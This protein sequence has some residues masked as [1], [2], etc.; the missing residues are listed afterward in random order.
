MMRG[1]DI[2]WRPFAGCS[3]SSAGS[4]AVKSRGLPCLLSEHLTN[5]FR[6][7]NTLTLR[8]QTDLRE[9]RW[10]HSGRSHCQP[11]WAIVADSGRAQLG[12]VSAGLRQFGSMGIHYSRVDGLRISM[13]VR[14]MPRKCRRR[15]GHFRADASSSALPGAH[16]YAWVYRQLRGPR[17]VTIL[18]SQRRLTFGPHDRYDVLVPPPNCPKLN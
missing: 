8:R 18:C 16:D 17:R 13:P 2:L 4:T 6:N 11:K 10:H 12:L 14:V 15:T 5:C 1:L 9:A 7:W 3:H